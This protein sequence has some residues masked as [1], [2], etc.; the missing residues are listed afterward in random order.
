MFSRSE[1]NEFNLKLQKP[2]Q[3]MSH[4]FQK[5]GTSVVRC[6]IHPKMKLKV[7]VGK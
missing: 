3:D 7:T 2:G 6:A 5:A 1:G 4:R